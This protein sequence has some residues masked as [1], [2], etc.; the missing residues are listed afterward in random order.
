[1]PRPAHLPFAV[2]P[3]RNFPSFQSFQN[4]PSRHEAGNPVPSGERRFQNA[5]DFVG[6]PIWRRKRRGMRLRMKSRRQ[7]LANRR[8][9]GRI[10]FWGS[11][12]GRGR[13]TAAAL[14]PFS[15]N[16]ARVTAMLAAAAIFVSCWNP[17]A[18]KLTNSLES[19]DLVVTNQADP[20]QVLQN[21]KVAY[22]FRDSLLYCDL[23]DTSFVFE[24]FNPD[25][26][27]SGSPDSWGRETDLRTTGRMFRHYQVIDLVWKSTLAERVDETTGELSRVFDLTLV[28]EDHDIQLSGYAVFSF[29]KCRDNRWRITHWKDVSDL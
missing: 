6:K 11:V 1:M 19:S 18:P 28:A 10:P 2:F 26:G 5:P 17:F 7:S 24:Y 14:P 3:G 20:A 27:T 15:A 25:L 8:V 4:H 16:P 22:T 12:R 9:P 29:R 21:F 23:L 13:N